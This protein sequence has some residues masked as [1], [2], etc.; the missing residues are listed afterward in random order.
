MN[1]ADHACEIGP[2]QHDMLSTSALQLRENIRARLGV[3]LGVETGT[4]G[5]F[6]RRKHREPYFRVNV[7]LA[8]TASAP[9]RPAVFSATAA[10]SP[11]PF[12]QG[13]FA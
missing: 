1:L 4:E 3:E 8:S 9:G 10:P 12:S 5:G 2:D 11:A 7:S 6:G 13:S